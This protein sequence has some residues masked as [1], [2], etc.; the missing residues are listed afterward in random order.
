M[1][2]IV[3]FQPK[4][5]YD[6]MILTGSMK[7]EQMIQG[8]LKEHKEGELLSYWLLICETKQSNSNHCLITYAEY[9]CLPFNSPLSLHLLH[10]YHIT[11]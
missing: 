11:I 9:A 7:T 3:P 4:P 8:K 10:C 1:T 6:S 5:F 2:S